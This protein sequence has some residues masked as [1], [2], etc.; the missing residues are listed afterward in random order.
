MEQE[1]EQHH[2]HEEK[3]QEQ[4]IPERPLECC[5][6]CRRPVR[7]IYTEIVGKNTNRWAM[8]DECP[9]LRHKLRGGG[10]V[11]TVSGEVLASLVCGGCGL[12]LDEVKMGASL[13]CPL[14]YDIFSDEVTRE[15]VQLE[16][17][18][19][20]FFLQK[21]GEPLHEGRSPG[22]QQQIDP[23]LKLLALQQALHETLGREDYEQAA[24]LRDQIHELEE[25]AKNTRE[26]EHG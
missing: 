17:V 8:C 13:G 4:A 26:K 3:P 15:L 18:P 11:A 20:K 22:Q 14:C 19:P 1:Q 5:G 10:K 21:K 9:V 7:V 24:L 2:E 16:R 6:E 25:K 12:A 23:S